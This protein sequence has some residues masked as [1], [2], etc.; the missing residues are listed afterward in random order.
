MPLPPGGP[1]LD[2]AARSIIMIVVMN[3]MMCCCCHSCMNIHYIMYLDYVCVIHVM[4]VCMCIIYIYVI[5][6]C[7]IHVMNIHSYIT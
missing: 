4:N 6:V 1:A 7:V 3:G 5:H 2:A